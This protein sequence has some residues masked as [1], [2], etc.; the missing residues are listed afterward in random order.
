MKAFIWDLINGGG[1]R[2]EESPLWHC[3]CCV[4]GGDGWWLSANSA[5]SNGMI[6]L[7]FEQSWWPCRYRRYES[8]RHLSYLNDK[9]KNESLEQLAWRYRKVISVHHH[10]TILYLFLSR[11]TLVR[12]EL[13]TRS[14]LPNAPVQRHDLWT[15][16]FIC[17]FKIF[18]Y[19]TYRCF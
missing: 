6:G 13:L 15:G 17:L 11:S 8:D 4:I 3:L 16:R 9:I 5:K 14:Y 19:H 18:S 2:E 10:K 7:I 12:F 1:G